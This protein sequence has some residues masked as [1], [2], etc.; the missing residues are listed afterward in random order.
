MSTYEDFQGRNSS[1]KIIL[2]KI[3]ASI[4]LIGFTLDSGSIYKITKD[5]AKIESMTD[6]GVGLT[7]VFGLSSVVP[8]SFFNDRVNKLIYVETSD[9][10]NPN[11]K[12][13]VATFPN[14]F[15]NQPVKAAYDL[16]TGFDV[17]WEPMVSKVSGFG[18]TLDNDDQIGFALEGGGSISLVNDS[19]FWDSRFEQFTWENQSAVV[20]SW[21]RD[22]DI[23]EAKLLFDGIVTSRSWSTNRISFRLKDQLKKIRRPYPLVN[24]EDFSGALIPDGLKLAKQRRIYGRLNGNMP[25]NIDQTVEGYLLAGTLSLTAGSATV[26]GVGTTFRNDFSPD[27]ELIIPFSPEDIAFTIESITSDTVMTITEASGFDFSGVTFSIVPAIPKNYINREWLVAGHACS[28]PT[29]TVVNAS[30]PN[31]IE[32]ASTANMSEGD[33]LFFGSPGSG[34]IA[35]IDKIFSDGRIR[36]TTNLESPPTSGLDVLRPAVQTLKINGLELAY[37]RDF[38]L[39]INSAKTQITLDPDAE[40][41]VS[42]IRSVNGTVIFNSTVAVTGSGTNFQSQLKV[43][44]H[45]RSVGEVPFFQ[46]MSIESDTALT[47]VSAASY[48]T[49]IGGQYK[50]LSNFDNNEDFLTCTIIGTTDDDTSEGLILKTAG[51]IVKDILD[52]SSITGLNTAS[53]DDADLKAPYLLGMAIPT[54][55]RST[56]SKSVRDIINQINLSVFGSLVQN[57]DF[58]LEYNILQ[59]NRSSSSPTLKKEDILKINID[60]DNDR[61]V[62]TVF[63]DYNHLELDPLSGEASFS[64]FKKVSDEGLY[65]T[66]IDEERII[67]TVLVDID[68]ARI[69]GNRWGFLLTNASNVIKITTKL[70]A[71]RFQVNDV[72]LIDHPKL[73]DR[74]GGGS[75][76]Y[77]AVQAI[78]K[79]ESTVLLE[80]DDLSNAFNRVC[81]ITDNDAPEFS[82]SNPRQKA[83]NG[84]ITDT[85]GLIEDEN[86]GLNLI[87]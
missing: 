35:T 20:Y 72:I 42:P 5:I 86:F 7:E 22:I 18:V 85:F 76:R 75:R 41:N 30:S 53:F 6:S 24:I 34:E 60:S 38:I 43:G 87:W 74:I 52:K 54:E 23:T 56:S 29:T 73:F 46:I 50:G 80:F 58:E 14:F 44:Q 64:C 63:V 15:S 70:Q 27:D 1:N 65:L 32:L 62:G 59:P 16:S 37:D 69:I 51:S 3:D 31:R 55:F 11:G 79:S 40:K 47:L 12:F 19:G 48:T 2:V 57:E 61:I 17:F 25:T 81:V 21:T 77:A 9:S 28:Q 39:T 4:R 83:L 8:G 82:D 13:L 84:Y 67:K 36:L 68:D 45:I 71:S 10:A 33:K 66:R 78:N 26:T 49:S